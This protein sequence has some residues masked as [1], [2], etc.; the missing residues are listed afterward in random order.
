M[1]LRNN[2]ILYRWFCNKKKAEV[3]K[4][5]ELFFK[6][7]NGHDLFDFAWNGKSH[8]TFVTVNG[9]ENKDKK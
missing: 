2:L 7:K 4:H 9:G 5:I 3:D 8:I 6:H 1:S